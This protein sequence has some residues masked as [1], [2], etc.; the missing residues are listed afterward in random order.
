M[1]R[2]LASLLLTFFFACAPLLAAPPVEIVR[3][4][5]GRGGFV[6][7]IMRVEPHEG[8]RKVCLVWYPE[9][10][11]EFSSRSCR[12][13]AGTEA[14]IMYTY[15][16]TLPHGG[17]WYFKGVVERNMGTVVSAPKAVIVGGP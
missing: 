4:A 3:I 16:R 15:E 13:E 7:V 1:S 12:D 11:E 2:I 10:L 9:E 5:A 8:T 17:I 14:P 6:R